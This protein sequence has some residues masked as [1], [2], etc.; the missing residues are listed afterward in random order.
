[1]I[2]MYLFSE[3]LVANCCHPNAF[4]SYCI[5]NAKCIISCFFHVATLPLH[6]DNAAPTHL[7]MVYSVLFLYTNETGILLFTENGKQ[8]K[9]PIEGDHSGRQQ[10]WQDIVDESVCE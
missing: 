4:D 6:F 7:L 9:G 1:M 2:K 5:T 3:S 8:K 10:R